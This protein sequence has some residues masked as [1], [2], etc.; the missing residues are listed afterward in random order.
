MTL[1]EFLDRTPPYFCRVMA[2]DVGRG[3]KVKRIPVKTLM[4]LSGLSRRTIVRMSYSKSW[5]PSW[6]LGMANNF[7]KACGVDL[8]AKDPVSHFLRRHS[9]G[10]CSY[11]LPLQRKKLEEL[12]RKRA[13][14]PA[15][16]SK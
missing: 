2:I 3:K 14:K 12:N 8:L 16:K 15:A 5:L 1:I 11:L 13:C 9:K 6:S 4:S 7:A 10:D